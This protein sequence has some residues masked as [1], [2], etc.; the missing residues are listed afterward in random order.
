[1]LLLHLSLVKPQYLIKEQQMDLRDL[2]PGEVK[3]P[4]YQSLGLNYYER[5]PK[6][7]KKINKPLKV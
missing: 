7:K 4:Q 1:M 3:Q 6:K 5:K 2:P